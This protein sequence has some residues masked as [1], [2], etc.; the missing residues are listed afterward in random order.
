MIFS[1]NVL[2]DD[3]IVV[4]AE[5]RPQCTEEE[6]SKKDGHIVCFLIVI[7]R[8]NVFLIQSWYETLHYF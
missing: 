8:G 1:V 6:V 3:R 7:F 5:Q 2:K 4:V